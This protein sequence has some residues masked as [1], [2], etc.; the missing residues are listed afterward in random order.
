MYDEAYL[1]EATIEAAERIK[2]ML[3]K[4]IL[5]LEKL[6]FANTFIEMC[7]IYRMDR[8]ITYYSIMYG[9]HGV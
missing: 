9:T 8:Y 7:E 5:E 2:Q 6:T 4:K 1:V 3:W